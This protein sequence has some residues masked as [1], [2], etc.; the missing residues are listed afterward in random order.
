MPE[1][2]LR[3][4]LSFVEESADLASLPWEYLYRPDRGQAQGVSGFLLMDPCLSMVRMAASKR[5]N[6]E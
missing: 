3:V 1:E 4:Q 5:I 6:C 2:R